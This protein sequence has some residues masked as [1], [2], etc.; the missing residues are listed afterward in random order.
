MKKR[1]L[2]III[3]IVAIGVCAA[4][5]FTNSHILINNTKKVENKLAAE[6]EKTEEPPETETLS[7]E[8][9][10]VKAEIAKYA[11]TSINFKHK[12]QEF[13]EGKTYDLTFSKMGSTTSESVSNRVTYVNSK[14][15]EFVYDLKTGELVMAKISSLETEKTSQSIDISAAETIAYKYASQ[16]CNIDEYVLDNKEERSNGYMFTYCK[17]VYGYKTNDRV[18]VLVGF[19][20]AI[21]WTAVRVYPVDNSKINVDKTWFDAQIKTVEESYQNTTIEDA[22]IEYN[23]DDFNGVIYFNIKYKSVSSVGETIATGVKSIEI[24]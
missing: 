14:D 18:K 17:Y 12:K 23:H 21:I 16:N 15:D 9:K 10:A 2:F 8:D 24:T 13:F 5:G 19:D 11:E 7:A 20:G 1:L 6:K 4:V 22:W 3:L